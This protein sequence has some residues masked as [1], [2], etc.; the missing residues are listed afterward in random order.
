MLRIRREE[1]HTGIQMQMAA[2]LL[3]SHRFKA[4]LML[5][6]C[7]TVAKIVK[8][9]TIFLGIISQTCCMEVLRHA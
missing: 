9:G 3:G 2:F 6:I 8:S 1:G 4:L 7:L 5:N